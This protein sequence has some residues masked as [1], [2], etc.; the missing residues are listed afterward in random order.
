M[1]AANPALP[2]PH[3]LTFTLE[4]FLANL[5]KVEE[6]WAGGDDPAFYTLIEQI[7]YLN[8]EQVDFPSFVASKT[9]PEGEASP[10]LAAF[11]FNVDSKGTLDYYTANAA[12]MDLVVA[13]ILGSKKHENIVNLVNSL[14]TVELETI[15]RE[16]MRCPHCWAD[17][18]EEV[19]GTAM[20]L[21][22]FL[23]AAIGSTR[24]ALSSLLRARA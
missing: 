9:G 18:D 3:G 10:L 12:L 8:M 21:S 22:V 20:S 24:T 13:H 5:A 14:P 4:D 6:H 1:S 15:S 23:A 17:F 2:T 11:L 16:D 19:E 7:C